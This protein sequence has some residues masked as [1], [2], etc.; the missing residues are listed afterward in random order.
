MYVKKNSDF[1]HNFRNYFDY[2][3]IFLLQ[4]L[5]NKEKRAKQY[6]LALIILVHIDFEPQIWY[7]IPG[8]EKSEPVEHLNGGGLLPYNRE[9]RFL[10]V[11]C[12][13]DEG[14]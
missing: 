11:V 5:V 3:T 14:R 13:P 9:C 10:F 2:Y 8:T 4:N 12:L 6:R 1:S 7:N